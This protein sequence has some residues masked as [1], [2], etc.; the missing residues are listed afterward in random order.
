MPE[1][2]VH[3]IQ[4][5]STVITVEADDCEAAIE[6]AYDK[7]PSDVCASCSGWNGSIGIELAG[8]WEPNVVYDADSNT[9]WS[10]DTSVTD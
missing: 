6:A 1:F 9:V 8:T 10:E 5:A 4:T 2:T 7:A 3:L